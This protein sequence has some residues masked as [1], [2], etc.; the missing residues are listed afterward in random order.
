MAAVPACVEHRPVT[1]RAALTRT[2]TTT[3]DRP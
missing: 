2:A 3:I 1:S